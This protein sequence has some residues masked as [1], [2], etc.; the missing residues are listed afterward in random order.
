MEATVVLPNGERTTLLK[1]GRTRPA[2]WC[3]TCGMVYMP[4]VTASGVR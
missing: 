1:I 2:L 3:R 4:P